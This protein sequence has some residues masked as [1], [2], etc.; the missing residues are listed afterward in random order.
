MGLATIKSGSSNPSDMGMYQ[1]WGKR[2]RT[3]LQ[4]WLIPRYVHNKPFTVVI[5]NSSEWENGFQSGT[6]MSLRQ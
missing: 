1:S 4:M 5:Y 2:K 6:Q 3:I